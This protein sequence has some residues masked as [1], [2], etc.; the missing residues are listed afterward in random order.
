MTRRQIFAENKTSTIVDQQI[1]KSWIKICCSKARPAPC[2]EN[3][4]GQ[5]IGC[6]KIR[7]GSFSWSGSLILHD[8]R[9]ALQNLRSCWKLKMDPTNTSWNIFW[10]L[11]A[12]IA[13]KMHGQ[14]HELPSQFGQKRRHAGRPQIF[15]AGCMI[16]II[17]IHDVTVS[18]HHLVY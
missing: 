7:V 4:F 8:S 6:C 1:E 17:L 15:I 13:W 9:Q 12:W 10:R 11:N 2:G 14:G 18:Y 16:K 5:K 3:W